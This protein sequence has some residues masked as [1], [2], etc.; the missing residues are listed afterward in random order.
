[1]GAG[2]LKQEEFNRSR[3]TNSSTIYNTANSRLRKDLL[4]ANSGQL[5][6]LWK[7]KNVKFAADQDKNFS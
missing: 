3:C 4:C 2:R 7:M 5:V 6:G 1:M